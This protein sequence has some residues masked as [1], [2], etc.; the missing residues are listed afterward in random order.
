MSKII[1]WEMDLRS[2]ESE[3]EDEIVLVVESVEEDMKYAN[4]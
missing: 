3:Q 4:E 1:E 2:L